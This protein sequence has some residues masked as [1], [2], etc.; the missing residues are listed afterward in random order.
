ML[1]PGEL[2]IEVGVDM[3]DVDVRVDAFVGESASID[4]L[5]T[6]LVIIDERSPVDV[7]GV[8]VS[9]VSFPL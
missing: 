8:V 5:D 7:A 9:D 3:D 2:D 4:E 1:L 6:E